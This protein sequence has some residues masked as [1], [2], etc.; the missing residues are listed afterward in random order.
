[1]EVKTIAPCPQK[2]KNDAYQQRYFLLKS[3]YIHPKPYPLEGTAIPF[4]IKIRQ[5]TNKY[6]A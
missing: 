2:P 3:K 4:L 5:I 1:L 6:L